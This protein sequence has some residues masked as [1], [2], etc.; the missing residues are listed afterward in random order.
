MNIK[1]QNSNFSKFS[2]RKFLRFPTK[3]LNRQKRLKIF[4]LINLIQN[5]QRKQ[6]LRGVLEN[7][8]SEICSQHFWK[9]PMK[10]FVFS[11]VEDLE[12]AIL[13]KLNFFIGVF[14]KDFTVNF[15]WELSK[16]LLLRTS[17]SR[18]PPPAT[19]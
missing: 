3:I 1:R 14:F 2:L 16:L 6:P 4:Q 8:C 12:S 7:R 19:S 11:K 13:P 9:I 5:K 18:A 15:T 10:K 17:F